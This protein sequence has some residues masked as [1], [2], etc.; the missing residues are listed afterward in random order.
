M[1]TRTTVTVVRETAD[2]GSEEIF[3]DA[4]CDVDQDL[5]TAEVLG[6]LELGK[7]VLLGSQ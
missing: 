1:S 5:S 2:D 6:I 4:T 7:S 3:V